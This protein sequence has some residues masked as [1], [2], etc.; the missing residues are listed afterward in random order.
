MQFC[1]VGLYFVMSKTFVLDL[2]LFARIKLGK[3][4]GGSRKGTKNANFQKIQFEVYNVLEQVLK[5]F[6]HT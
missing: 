3:I 6:F 1:S 5:K 2:A 4:E